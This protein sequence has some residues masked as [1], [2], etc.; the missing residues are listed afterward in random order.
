MGMSE[1]VAK[2]TRVF[3]RRLDERLD[4]LES[5]IG[6]I[7]RCVTATVEHLAL[8]MMSIA[9]VYSRMD[10]IDAQL[11]RVDRRLDLTDAK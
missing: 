2:L 3:M 6:D 10:M 5:D 8:M 1:D 7:K 9:G 11:A 4:R